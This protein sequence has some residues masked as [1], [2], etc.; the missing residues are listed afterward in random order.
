MTDLLA[1]ARPTD[2]DTDTTDRE[3]AGR[4]AE[5]LAAA[6][7][8]AAPAVAATHPAMPRRIRVEALERSGTPLAP[9]WSVA[10]GADT[11]R[12]RIANLGAAPAFG[13]VT[14]QFYRITGSAGMVGFGALAIVA[15]VGGLPRAVAWAALAAGVAYLLVQP[16]LG[17]WARATLR[18]GR[19]ERRD[20]AADTPL[21]AVLA[22]HRHVMALA[23]GFGRVGDH[24]QVR[25]EL[26]RLLWEAVAVD[27]AGDRA[28]ADA[29]AS[30]CATVAEALE[31]RITGH[32]TPVDAGG[33]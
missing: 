3:A 17:V 25:A 30:H 31:Q 28:A 23:G 20:V 26:H 4:V 32:A 1:P 14:G 12:R 16:A 33:R 29:M 24:R 27:L 6:H 11:W 13:G 5:A 19:L 2:T 21:G 10:L 8:A 15:L 9:E 18:P 22:F 7:L